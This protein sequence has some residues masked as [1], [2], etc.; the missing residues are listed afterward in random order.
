M[1]SRARRKRVSKAELARRL[2]CHLPLE[3]DRLLDY[4]SFIMRKQIRSDGGWCSLMLGKR[5]DISLADAA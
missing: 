3:Y 5:L 2:N 1:R 4:E